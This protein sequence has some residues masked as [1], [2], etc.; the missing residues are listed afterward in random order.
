MK[1]LFLLLAITFGVVSASYAQ[2]AD[3][4][5]DN[6]KEEVVAVDKAALIKEDVNKYLQTGLELMKT[7]LESDD[8]KD[9]KWTKELP[10]KR[11]DNQFLY[12]GDL[13]P[14]LD[15]KKDPILAVVYS[16]LSLKPDTKFEYCNIQVKNVEENLNA[17]GKGT[18][19]YTV[20]ATFEAKTTA[21]N[22]KISRYT[23]TVNWWKV[24]VNKSNEVA[25]TRGSD[26]DENGEKLSAVTVAKLDY[27]VNEAN[28]MLAE[29]RE[30]AKGKLHNFEFVS[31][32]TLGHP[33]IT[34]ENKPYVD[35]YK[36]NSE[37]IIT[38][39]EYEF[40]KEDVKIDLD[41]KQFIKKEEEHLYDL[42]DVE[43]LKKQSYITFDAK[44]TVV[45]SDYGKTP[46][47]TVEYIYDDV[48]KPMTNAEREAI[49][50]ASTEVFNGY[51]ASL[52]TLLEKK[53]K[54]S[55]EEALKMFDNE[56]TGVIVS[57]KS[58]NGKERISKPI[59]AKKYVQRINGES[60]S[61]EIVDTQ[62]TGNT[63][64]YTFDQTFKSKAYSDKVTK[65]VK[66][67]KNENE[68]YKILS[69][70][71]VENTTERL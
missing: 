32:E 48:V 71:V 57:Y 4:S 16:A 22:G 28:E 43:S 39:T 37:N 50:N 35:D 47:V 7:R 56:K 9:A 27:T 68:E 19:K 6:S 70:E 51:F 69:I 60:F 14:E 26:K 64:S 65:V 42:N 62:L 34:I 53:D 31:A 23:V 11:V 59:D 20:T 21:N 63:V 52:N 44:Y 3:K 12:D 54:A 36:F 15:L 25:Y 29:A 2:K 1:K 58:K 33:E 40:V 5:A 10:F 67:G 45:F 8:P 17:K 24:T 55:R 46:E 41:Y 66:L 38:K 18:G 13:I 49:I 61:V 30:A